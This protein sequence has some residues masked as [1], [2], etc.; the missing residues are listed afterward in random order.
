MK[1]KDFLKLFF[2]IALFMGLMGC[3]END[4]EENQF[5]DCSGEEVIDDLTVANFPV[6]DGSDWTEFLWRV[7]ACETLDINYFWSD[8]LSSSSWRGIYHGPYTDLP[9]RLY[10]G[11][12]GSIVNL[13]DKE[14]DCILTVRSLSD[15][16]KAYA[17]QQGVS[18]LETPVALDALVFVVNTENPV[19]SLSSSQIQGIYTGAI[20]NWTE[21]G[22][23]NQEIAPYYISKTAYSDAY[24]AMDALVMD[25]QTMIDSTEMAFNELYPNSHWAIRADAKGIKFSSLYEY[26]LLI[27]SVKEGT[28]V[29]R[30]NGIEPTRENIENGTYRYVTKVYAVIRADEDPASTTYQVYDKLVHSGTSI[31]EAS[32]FIP[33][34][35]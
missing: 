28:K 5:N 6:M 10:S 30:V 24:E 35:E 18:L 15:E 33:I 23:D 3:T 21:V 29:L 27:D 12:H 4:V 26:N 13:I 16:E 25:G 1:T 22:G 20:Q 32:R 9:A 2:S 14:V 17:R 31:I 11:T 8:V 7:L 19:N 34:D